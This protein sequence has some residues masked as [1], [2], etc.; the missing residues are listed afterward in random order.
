MKIAFIGNSGLSIYVYRHELVK[1]LLE[2]GYDVYVL[3][4]NGD[5]VEDLK[6]M[7]CKHYETQLERHGKNPFDDLKLLGKY[8]KLLREISPD[9]VFT[10]TIKP[11]IYGSMACARLDIPCIT[12]IT[13]LGSA[14]ENGGI[15]Q[16]ITVMLY[17]IAFRKIKTVFFQNEENRQFFVDRRI[18]MGKHKLLPGSGV[19]LTRFVPKPLP[20]N[21]TVDFVF[22]SRLLKEK[23]IEQY[24]DAAKYIKNKYP[25]TRFHICGYCEKEYEER[26]H[27]L[28]END[29]VI[30]HGLVKDITTVLND[31]HCVV[32]P[33]F[34]PE[35]MS[36][37]LLEA[38]ACA[39]PIIATD[40]AGCR[41]I[42]DDGINGF[43]VKQRDSEDLIRQIEKFLALSDEERHEMGRNGR[44]KVEK[45]FD[46]NIVV[47]AYLKE[48]GANSSE[49]IKI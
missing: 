45:Q 19:N 18:A 40:R 1:K 47:N 10:Y 20:D 32:H 41:E 26:M 3:C 7:G 29:T 42:V 11:N 9:Y 34:Y 43:V 44:A 14:V 5:W 33:S 46:R 13:G 2:E 23:G 49:F 15:M 21:G 27:L 48:I 30:Y 12:N 31:V 6:A 28:R 24:L 36:N 8:K 22:I 17:K 39:R 37:V 16:K 38:C 35:G 25:Y 4:P